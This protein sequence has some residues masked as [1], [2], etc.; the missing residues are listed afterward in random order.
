MMSIVRPAIIHLASLENETQYPLY[1]YDKGSLHKLSQTQEWTDEDKRAALFLFAKYRRIL[2]R[3]GFDYYAIFPKN[4]MNYDLEERVKKAYSYLDYL[5][6]NH[7]IKPPR[8]FDLLPLEDMEKWVYDEIIKV[9]IDHAR[10]DGN[11]QP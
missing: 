9:R 10:R 8:G 1:L 4:K 2:I 6:K 3:D 7:N 11:N 5:V